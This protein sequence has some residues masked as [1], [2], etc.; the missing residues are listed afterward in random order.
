M[1]QNKIQLFFA[2]N[3]SKFPPATLH[4]I[5]E[6]LEKMDDTG[7]AMILSVPYKDPVT[8]LIISLLVGHFGVDRFM[9][10]ETGTGVAK[11]LTCGGLGIWTIVD[12]FLV[13]D[14]TRQ[15]NYVT[16]MNAA[17]TGIRF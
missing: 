7:Y 17:T 10:G 3:G 14:M 8:M 6:Q 9:L 13:M 2:T 12:W 5:K 15:Y 4:V 11:L 1:D 16:F